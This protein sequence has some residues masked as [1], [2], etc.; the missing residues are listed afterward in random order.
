VKVVRDGAS[1]TVFAESYRNNESKAGFTANAA[2][3]T[4]ASPAFNNSG[5]SLYFV[6]VNP[7]NGTNLTATAARLQADAREAHTA[8]ERG[9]G[10]RFRATRI[11]STTLQ[12]ILDVDARLD[13]CAMDLIGT[14][15][16]FT[17]TGRA[18]VG[19]SSPAATLDLDQTSA[20]GAIPVLRLDQGDADVALVSFVG[21]TGATG[22]S[23]IWTES[24][25]AA[26]ALEGSIKVLING[27]VRYI[28]FHSEI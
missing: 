23:T 22:A 7:W 26:Y 2:R 20:T 10:W 27:A 28:K 14:D 24:N 21:S 19:V 5:D 3:G 15:S 8:T 16:R 12:N 25:D 13:G 1:A 11:G 4:K 17:M 6:N 9:T 18:G